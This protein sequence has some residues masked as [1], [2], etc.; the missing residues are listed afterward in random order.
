M[1]GAFKPKGY[2][3]VSPYIMANDAQRIIDFVTDV[4][5]ATQ[6]RRFDAPDGSTAH[7]EV[8]IDDSVIMIADAGS[9]TPAFPV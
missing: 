7:V 2:A 8:Q 6:L 3:S 1:T 9:E 5:G 4:F